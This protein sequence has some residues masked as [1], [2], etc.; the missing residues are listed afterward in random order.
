MF[1]IYNSLPIYKHLYLTDVI[2]IMKNRFNNSLI[3]LII[4]SLD[5][6]S[7]F[8]RR[9]KAINISKMLHS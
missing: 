5:M 4:N 7:A 6:I 3:T 9:E 8:S 1:V 2:T